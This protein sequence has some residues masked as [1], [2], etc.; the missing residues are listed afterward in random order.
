LSSPHSNILHD[1][2][3]IL[4]QL[5][6]LLTAACNSW[7][8]GFALFDRK[9]RYRFVNDGLAAM[10]RLSVKAHVG[11]PLRAILADTA[12]KVEPV[13]EKVFS[14][15]KAV[16]NYEFSGGFPSRRE[17]ACWR[18]S[19]FPLCESESN[20]S[21]IAAIVF[22][23]TILRRVEKQFA[24]LLGFHGPILPSEPEQISNSSSLSE[25]S[26]REV[27][28]LKLLA[29]G[30]SNKQVAAILGLSVRTVESHRARMMLKLRVRS[31]PELVRFAIRTKV[32][33]I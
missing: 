16:L 23:L 33:E 19:Y 3:Q 2:T 14:T 8:I 13:F 12:E 24:E 31:L 1:P 18:T 20:V 22:D 10:N 25:L 6:P 29:S 27:E 4:N 28:T 7:S 9:L 15:G 5:E 17:E 11:A 30:N 26:G 21:Q 32:V